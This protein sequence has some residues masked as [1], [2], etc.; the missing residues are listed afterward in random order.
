[1]P[2]V[3]SIARYASYGI[4]ARGAGM[5]LL[6]DGEPRE[7]EDVAAAILSHLAAAAKEATGEAPTAAVLTIPYYFG[8]R[9]RAA[10]T[11]AA[12]RA[13]LEARQ[14]IS[15]GTAI[16]LSLAAAEP[17]QRRIAVA[18]VGAGGVTVSI[19][20]LGPERVILVASTGDPAG[21]GD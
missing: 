11:E 6:V 5:A 19:L 7:P 17:E 16:A 2:L 9:Q 1:D 21:G 13:G 14:I 20:E 10:L 3:V 8:A 18:D 4:A 12:R 15:E